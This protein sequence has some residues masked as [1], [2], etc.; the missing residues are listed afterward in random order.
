MHCK[1]IPHL[2]ASFQTN[3]KNTKQNKDYAISYT[4]QFH[5][6][7]TTIAQNQE[8]NKFNSFAPIRHYSHAHCLQLTFKANEEKKLSPSLLLAMCC[9]YDAIDV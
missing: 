9:G 8:K 6:S 5:S 3:K 4:L 2:Q 7:F 1:Q